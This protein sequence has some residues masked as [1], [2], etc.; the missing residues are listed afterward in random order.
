LGKEKMIVRSFIMIKK[1]E[2]EE[3]ARGRKK[4][5]RVAI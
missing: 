1:K 3:D 5:R 4:E 2:G